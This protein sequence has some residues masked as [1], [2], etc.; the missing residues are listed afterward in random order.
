MDGTAIDFAQQMQW[1]V[2]EGYPDAKVIRVVLDNLNTHTI[3]SLYAAFPPQETRRLARKLE[4]H[5]TPKHGSWL[6]I[7]ECELAVLA[8]SA[9]PPTSRAGRRRRPPSPGWPVLAPVRAPP[10][11]P[12]ARVQ[13]DVFGGRRV[14]GSAQCGGGRHLLALHDGAGSSQAQPR[15]SHPGLTSMVTH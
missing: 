8:A 9:R 7:A 13:Q 10:Q 3:A 15:L 4:F 2:D 6:N 14:G 12:T 5:D 11:S 1:L